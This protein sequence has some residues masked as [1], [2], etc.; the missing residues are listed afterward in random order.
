MKWK[1]LRLGAARIAARSFRLDSLFHK[2]VRMAQSRHAILPVL[3]ERGVDET[4]LIIAFSGNARKLSV[5]VHE[6]FETTKTLGYNRILLWDKHTMYYHY[7]VDRQRRDWPSLIAYLEQ[8]IARLRPKT[9]L[10]VGTSSGGYAAIV[11]GHHLK[12][13]FVHAFSPQTF[14]D[15]SQERIRRARH[16]IQRWRM[17]FSRR[18]HRGLLDLAPMLS[19]FNGKTRYFLHYGAEHEGD[20]RYADRIAGMPSVVTLGYPCKVH[21]IAIY[22][23]KEQFL[24]HVLVLRNQ[25]RLAEMARKHFG[26][27]MRITSAE[28]AARADRRAQF[29]DIPDSAL[30]I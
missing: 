13:D 2:Q 14:I 26:E 6:F 8:E 18:I 28:S 27:K 21:A 19:R 24:G 9:V 15:L 17:S 11:A 25:A 4:V 10:C 5:P 1:R 7:G 29:E 12:A 30:S 16:P 20:R 23:A 22:L 3:C